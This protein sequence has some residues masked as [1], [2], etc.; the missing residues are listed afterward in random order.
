VDD[1]MNGVI[2][3]TEPVEPVPEI[4]IFKPHMPGPEP[5]PWLNKDG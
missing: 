3:K 5:L 1:E 4:D 2:R